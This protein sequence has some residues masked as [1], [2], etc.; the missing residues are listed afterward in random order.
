MEVFIE[1]TLLVVIAAG[2]AF[3][4]QLLK[5]PLIPAYVLAG[6]FLGPIFKLVT[7][8]SVIAMMSELGIAFLLFIVGLEIDIRKLRDVGFTAVWSGML[9]MAVLFAIGFLVAAGFALKSVEAVHIGFILAFSSTMVVVK[10]LADRRELETLHSRLILG[11]L[12]VQDLVAVLALAALGSGGQLSLVYILSATAKGL[13]LLLAV[14]VLSKLAFPHLFKYAARSREILFLA[15]LSVCLFF[16]SAAYF[17]GFSISI[18]AF[19]AG[20]S[21]ANLHYNLEIMG[22]VKPL[23]D[24]F[25]MIFF[26]SLG[27]TLSFATFVP[28]ALACVLIGVILVV[29]PLVVAV[30]SAFFGYKKHTSFLTGCGLVPVSE[31][32]LIMVSKAMATGQ[33]SAALLSFTVTA[34]IISIIASSYLMEYEGKIYMKFNR[35]LS[36]LDRLSKGS[37]ELVFTPEKDAKYD[38]ILIGHNRIGSRL[39]ETIKQKGKKI[40]VVDYNPDIVKKLIEDGV[41]CLYGDISDEEVCGRINLKGVKMVISTVPSYED[42]LHLVKRIKAANKKII[43]FATASRI[44]DALDLY[45]QGADYIIMPHFL[46]GDHASLLVD[47]FDSNFDNVLKTKLTHIQELKIRKEIGHEHPRYH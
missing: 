19:L 22:K 38:V 29:K 45:S 9:E 11:I 5:Q 20:L 16:A 36:W 15:S 26:V 42:N 24:F 3:L 30:I 39:A 33:V 13:S 21:L 18:G 34:A 14:W 25:A 7:N 41:H 31:F 12:L 1:I 43:L 23:R 27:L 2:M 46:G 44:D 32:S 6:L 28:I 47:D 8:Q 35:W 17:L 37:R 40:L 4:A 10:I